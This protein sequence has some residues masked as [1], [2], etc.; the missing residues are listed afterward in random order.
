MDQRNIPALYLL[1]A[2]HDLDAALVSVWALGQED[3]LV[4]ALGL[5]PG[6]AC[7]VALVA[8]C[9]AEAGC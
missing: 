2:A 6:V 3:M 8:R 7:I 1:V 5:G 4:R 9:V